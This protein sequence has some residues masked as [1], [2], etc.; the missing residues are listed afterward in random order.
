VRSFIELHGGWVALASEPGR[1]VTVTCN[2]PATAP[3]S[4]PPP[5]PP[6]REAA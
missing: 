4:A 1:G 5:T 6:S 2:L 3:A